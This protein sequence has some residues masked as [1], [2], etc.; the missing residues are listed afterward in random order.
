MDCKKIA[1]SAF[2]F[3]IISQIVHTLGAFASMGYYTDPQYFGL[4]SRL[5][6]PGPSPPGWE[7]Y[8]ASI[9]VALITGAIFT[10]IFEIMRP[11]LMANPKKN[12]NKVTPMKAGVKFGALIFLAVCFTNGM[13]AWLLYSFPLGLQCEWL[14][15]G[16]AVSLLYGAALGRIYK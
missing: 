5:M 10:Y 4:W 8:A 6:M 7:F 14:V 2:V 16:L 3:A 1:I 9:A 12:F 15:E 13:S 11:A